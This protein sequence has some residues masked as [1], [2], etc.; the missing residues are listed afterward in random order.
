MNT[1]KTTT[2]LHWNSRAAS[3]ANDVEVNLMDIFQREIE[4]DYVC[5][6]LEP[7]MRVLEVG[8]GNGFSTDRFRALVE[9]V[10]AF[11]Y[12]EQMIERARTAFG[13]TNN[14]FIH[15]NVLSPSALDGPYDCTICVRVLI[16]LAG[17]DEQKR[18]ISNL[19]ELTKPNG[20]LILAEGFTDGFGSL[21]DLRAA[22]GLPLLEP[23]SINFYSAMSDLQPTLDE[24][25]TLEE[26]FH[27]G[28]Y[29]YLTRVLYPLV[30]GPENAKHNSN[31]S[32][33][34]SDLAR[35]F[36]PD[37]FAPLSRMRGLV[38]RRR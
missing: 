9:H 29:D 3:V 14:R 24:A 6:Y 25:F 20:I 33:R 37:D 7:H 36:N 11:D 13:E 31:F 15:D 27:L 28:A 12:A 5:R 30:V 10:D 35:A 18:A 22:V 38:L 8:C 2:D 21:N 19:A 32:E 4:Y 16:N 23:A 26:T 1:K 17:L 34:C